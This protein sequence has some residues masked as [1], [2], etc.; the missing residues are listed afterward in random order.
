M[1]EREC[2]GC[3]STTAAL[4]EYRKEWPLRSEE[5]KPLCDLCAS[6][7]V[8]QLNDYAHLRDN[9]ELVEIQR[10]INYVGNV[11]LAEI[12]KLRASR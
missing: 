11:I 10:Q 9:P 1:D 8:G 4:T 7:K 5:M 12:A 3:G 6:T 2:D